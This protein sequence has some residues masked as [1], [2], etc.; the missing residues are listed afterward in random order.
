MAIALLTE[1]NKV[2]EVSFEIDLGFSLTQFLTSYR[3]RFHNNKYIILNVKMFYTAEE[4]FLFETFFIDTLKYGTLN[5]ETDLGLGFGV[6]EYI[7]TESPN[8]SQIEA[9]LYT[10][11]LNLLQVSDVETILCSALN[12]CLTLLIDNLKGN[13]SYLTSKVQASEDKQHMTLCLINLKNLIYTDDVNDYKI[14][15]VLT[16]EVL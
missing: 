7:I 1:L 10:V 3:K 6:K 11:E 13:N 15:K 16:E 5:F 12:N 9:D 8:F 14:L 4:A 2:N